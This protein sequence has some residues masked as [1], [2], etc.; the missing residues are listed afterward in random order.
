VK[1]LTAALL[2]PVS[3]LPAVNGLCGAATFWGAARFGIMLVEVCVGRGRRRATFARMAMHAGPCSL[4]CCWGLL[5]L[6][7]IPG[8]FIFWRDP[9]PGPGQAGAFIVKGSQ[10]PA[11]GTERRIMNGQ[12]K[13]VELL[14]ICA[15]M[16]VL[17][18][19]AFWAG[20]VH[21]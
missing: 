4:R 10:H 2:V 17:Y 9:W 5:P 12:D 14:V 19:A 20:L 6:R 16:M 13:S 18:I 3:L 8:N 21:G 7:Q 11:A 1:S 15:V